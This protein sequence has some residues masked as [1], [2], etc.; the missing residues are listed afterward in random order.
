[1]Y[2]SNT[3]T[4]I[5]LYSIPVVSRDKV[6]NISRQLPFGSDG[7]AEKFNVGNGGGATGIA[8]NSIA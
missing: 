6:A 8:R 7:V 4:Y 5:H 1:M 3:K 2:N